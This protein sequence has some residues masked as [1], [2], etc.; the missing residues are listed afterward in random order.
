MAR[1]AIDGMEISPL[2]RSWQTAPLPNG[3]I[4]PDPAGLQIAPYGSSPSPWER[5]LQLPG[6]GAWEC[7][8]RD[9]SLRWTSGVFDIFGLPCDRRVARPEAVALYCEES[10]E[11]M[12]RLRAYAIAHRRGFTMDAQI[13]R[14]DGERRWM[15][16]TT[17]VICDG[18]RASRLYGVKQDITQ[19]YA[20][21]KALRLLAETD[22]LT[23]LANRSRFEAHFLNGATPAS[24]CSLP[25]GLLIV[26]V[27]E[28]HRI[29]ARFGYGAGDACLQALASRLTAGF[30]DAPLIA[31]LGD[32]EFAVV[33]RDGPAA[34]R[35]ERKAARVLR[36]LA[37]P[38]YWRGQM[39]QPDLS[40]GMALARDQQEYDPQQLL[41]LACDRLRDAKRNAKLARLSRP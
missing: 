33:L 38:V 13:V 19:D 32:D 29:N 9:D 26:D 28:F 14:T 23:G 6:L 11:V 39:V 10:R 7:D 36:Y 25:G 35:L 30:A 8:L 12:E 34:A 1:L 20:N 24:P 27:D 15:R 21:R 17:G 40:A 4:H 37:E 41:A 18:G 5:A 31:R 2:D 16:L 22:P 3:I